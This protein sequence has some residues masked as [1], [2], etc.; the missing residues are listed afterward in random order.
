MKTAFFSL[1]VVLCTSISTIGQVQ[2]EPVIITT[3]V[4]ATTWDV[5]IE[6]WM[7]AGE[8]LLLRSMS[9]NSVT[10]EFDF[11]IVPNGNVGGMRWASVTYQ[12]IKQPTETHVKAETKKD[13]KKKGQAI[14]VYTN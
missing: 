12:V 13:K 3:Q 4:N 1:L 14:V 9:L 2:Y 11:D 5:E 6:V 10:R 7:P 8:D